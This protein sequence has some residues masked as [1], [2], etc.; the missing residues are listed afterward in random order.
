[1]LGTLTY[2]DSGVRDHEKAKRNCLAVVS[3]GIR[4]E[5]GFCIHAS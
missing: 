3:L 1:M 5:V 4:G 2:I